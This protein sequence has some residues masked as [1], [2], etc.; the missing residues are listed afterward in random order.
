M[1][2]NNV[3]ITPE[4]YAEV[5]QEN[6]KLR[7]EL[8]RVYAENRQLKEVRGLQRLDFMFKILD[9]AIHFDQETLDYVVAEVKESF[10]IGKENE[11]TKDNS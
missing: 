4:E 3:M 5:S 8:R 11:T 9:N 1:E 6:V 2:E 7:D 10:G